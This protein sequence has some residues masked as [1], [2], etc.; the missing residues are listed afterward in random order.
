M[1]TKLMNVVYSNFLASTEQEISSIATHPG[2]VNTDLDQNLESNTVV[3]WSSK[4]REYTCRSA[5]RGLRRLSRR[6]L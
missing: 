5:E 2:L 3:Y 6:R 4:F 1:D